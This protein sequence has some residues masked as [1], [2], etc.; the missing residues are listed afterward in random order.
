MRDVYTIDDLATGKQCLI[1]FILCRIGHGKFIEE[2]D[3]RRRFPKSSGNSTY[4][5]GTQTHD[6]WRVSAMTLHRNC[7]CIMVKESITEESTEEVGFYSHC[8]HLVAGPGGHME[9]F[10]YPGN[11]LF[12]YHGPGSWGSVQTL[13]HGNYCQEGRKIKS[14]I[15]IQYFRL[16]Q[17]D[18]TY[19]S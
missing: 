6:S 19:I 4:G 16:Q 15:I 9:D 7:Y 17:W 12:A 13:F 8:Y 2:R 18:L 1:I 11:V 5:Q 14:L 3:F 10:L